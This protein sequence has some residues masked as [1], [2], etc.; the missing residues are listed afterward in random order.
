MYIVTN[1][2]LLMKPY[3]DYTGLKI[4]KLK[5]LSKTSHK[6]LKNGNMVIQWD[7]VCDCG[8]KAIRVSRLLKRGNCCCDRC[9]AKINQ[10]KTGD[11]SINQWN[12]IKRQ[13]IIREITFDVQVEYGW[14]LFEKQNK[15]CAISGL[16]LCFGNTKYDETTASLDRIDSNKGYEKDNVQWVHKWI[17]LMKSDFDQ[18]EFIEMCRTVV[19]YNS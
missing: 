5:V 4:G 2:L 17:N 16:P 1:A 15:K 13:A 12:R 11:I 10:K 14:E 6:I 3:V 8:E 19:E 7:C 18:Q 9:R